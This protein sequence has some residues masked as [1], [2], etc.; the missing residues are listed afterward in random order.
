MVLVVDPGES[1]VQLAKAK[2]KTKNKSTATESSAKTDDPF[3][4]FCSE[5][6][7]NIVPNP[8]NEICKKMSITPVPRTEIISPPGSPCKLRSKDFLSFLNRIGEKFLIK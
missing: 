7:V 1:P 3:A 4:F 8:L 2:P 5:C 6:Q